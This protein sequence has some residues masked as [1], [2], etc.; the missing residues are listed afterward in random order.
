[1]TEND[2]NA[3]VT[4]QTAAA[5]PPPPTPDAPRTRLRDR[6]FR[7]RA[8]LAVAA[9]GIIV[10]AAGGTVT[11][12]LVH[13]DDDGPRHERFGGRIEERLEGRFGDGPGGDFE[14]PGMPPGG[15]PALPPDEDDSGGRDS[16]QDP[17][18]QNS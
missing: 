2:Q 15:M 14:P 5:A 11:T 8:V 9:A 3:P 13:G 12:L 4:P 7:L 18:Q 17:D 16:E 1:M 6:A 10:G